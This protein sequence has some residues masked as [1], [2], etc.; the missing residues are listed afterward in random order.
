MEY[1][2]VDNIEEAKKCDDLLTELIMSERK[3]DDNVKESFRVNN[4]FT[5]I[6]DKDYNSLI[7]VLCDNDIIGFI[8]GFLKHEKGEFAKENV[9]FIDALYVK[10]EYRKQ[11]IAS[12]LIEEFYKW[13]KLKDV[14]YI[15]IGSFVKNE[16]AFSLY[17]KFGFEVT[18]Y[19]MRKSI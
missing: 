4:Y 7:C 9:G 2:I 5:K 12:Q 8:Y 17:K 14:K 19:Y 1:K 6:Y 10:D 11:G 15:E 3:Y 13:C 18:T 16:A